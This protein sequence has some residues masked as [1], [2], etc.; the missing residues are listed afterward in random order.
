MVYMETT[1]DLDAA[2]AAAALLSPTALAEAAENTM[3]MHAAEQNVTVRHGVEVPRTT[4][5]YY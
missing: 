4:T 3:A 2:V 5:G 1:N